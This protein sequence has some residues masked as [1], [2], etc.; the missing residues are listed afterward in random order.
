MC[1]VA[2]QSSR[3]KVCIA[4]ASEYHTRQASVTSPITWSRIVM[5]TRSVA[6]I[7][8]SEVHKRRRLLEAPETLPLA[9]AAVV[10][11]RIIIKK[12]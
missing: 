6:L 8:W 2:L 5:N 11:D 10:R 3:R 12:A 1:V 4:A 7:G 9:G